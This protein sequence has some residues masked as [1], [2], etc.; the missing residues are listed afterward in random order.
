ME[1]TGCA[2]AGAICTCATAQNPRERPQV[3]PAY[4]L[5]DLRN[6]Q[7]DPKTKS[8][9]NTIACKSPL[10]KTME[11]DISIWQKPG[12]FYFALPRI[13]SVHSQRLQNS[14]YSKLVSLETM[15]VDRSNPRRG[16]VRGGWRAAAL[17]GSPAAAVC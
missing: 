8:H 2:T 10:E 5:Q 7:Q 3:L 16:R 6:N 4:G 1:A 11:A 9:P 17:R 12:H 14:G 15:L 13:Q